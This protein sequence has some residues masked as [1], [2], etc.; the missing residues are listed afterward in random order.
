M[1]QRTGKKQ[2]IAQAEIFPV[3]IAKETWQSEISDRSVLWFLDN[4]S[5]RLALIRC[6]SPVLDNFCLLQLNARLDSRLNARHW[7]SRV[8]SKSNPADDASR[9][10]FSAYKRSVQS[11]PCYVAAKEAIQRFWQLMR[12]VEKG[13]WE[14]SRTSACTSLKC[15]LLWTRCDFRCI[16]SALQLW[17]ESMFIWFAGIFLCKCSWSVCT[18]GTAPFLD[19]IIKQWK[20]PNEFS[21]Q[22]LSIIMFILFAQ[23]VLICSKRTT[24]LQRDKG[25]FTEGDI[26]LS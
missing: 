18:F 1:W 8:P 25:C 9:L 14:S 26:S 15:F 7:Y 3:L 17:H 19:R 12:K 4:D 10:E 22:I 23:F 2:V 13:C 24:L 20:G 21:I 6:F 11:G 5:A 16:F